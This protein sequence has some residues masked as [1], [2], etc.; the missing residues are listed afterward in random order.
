[1]STWIN[2]IATTYSKT[3][4]IPS[5]IYIV[6][7]IAALGN[8]K[9][10]VKELTNEIL[11]SSLTDYCLKMYVT[12]VGTDTTEVKSIFTETEYPLEK[13]E[14]IN[15]G[16]LNQYE[17]PAI[18]KIIELATEL[19]DKTKILYI[20]TKGVSYFNTRYELTTANWRHFM[21]YF[22]IK[23]W[24][25]CVNILEDFDTV[26]ILYQKNSTFLSPHY[27]G[28]FW[29]ANTSYLKKCQLQ[30]NN[31]YAPEAFIGTG[32]PNYFCFGFPCHNWY[33][34]LYDWKKDVKH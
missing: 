15:A 20:H 30:T 18:N 13:L 33:E 14:F 9:E 16:S 22:N 32:N 28:N 3:Q 11:I 6:F 1:M 34:I 25:R 12:I 27:S 10:V 7:H 24:K 26:G 4:I 21:S 29:W 23:E 19:E 5:K 31:R 8:W 2:P 17:F